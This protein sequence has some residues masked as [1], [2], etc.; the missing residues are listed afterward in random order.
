MNTL[1]FHFNDEFQHHYNCTFFNI[2]SVPFEKR[3]NIPIGI[4]FIVTSIAFSMLYVPCIVVM[5]R[6]RFT[7]QP[8]YKLMLYL[9]C[10]NTIA[11]L[12]VGIWG[13]IM[14]ILGYVYC[15][16]PLFTYTFGCFAT[17]LWFAETITTILLALNRCLTMRNP[18]L[19]KRLFEGYGKHTIDFWLCL[20][21]IGAIWGCLYCR[22]F[23]VNSIYGGH[24]K[25]PYLGYVNVS[26]AE[27][28]Y[29][30]DQVHVVYNW[31]IASILVTIYATFFIF[32]LVSN[33][34]A[35]VADSS[36]A[37]VR[38]REFS[39]FV[40]IFIICLLCVL[41]AVGYA[42]NEFLLRLNPKMVLCVS[43]GYVVFQGSPAII[44]LLLNKTIRRELLLQ[45]K[46]GHTY[47]FG[48][49]SAHPSSRRPSTNQ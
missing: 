46:A 33:R 41:S 11:M 9:A 29:Y 39:V 44:Y 13:G 49:S 23:L 15:T 18:I 8:C 48:G 34:M 16:S 22:P 37:M 35:R 12:L 38:K 10:V 4:G 30:Q 28:L 43:F 25:N 3:K 36:S 20:P 40:Q 31:V 14:L 21:T 45:I 32:L 26:E 6:E 42:Y 2:D 1:L 24:F 5:C 19:A 27:L 7:S 17:C 47:T